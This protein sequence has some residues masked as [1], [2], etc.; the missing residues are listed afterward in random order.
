MSNHH[1]RDR[2]VATVGV[3]LLFASLCVGSATADLGG[4]QFL[5]APQI[6]VP[7]GE[8][9]E[10]GGAGAGVGV[11]WFRPIDPELS[12]VMSAATLAFSRQS[13]AGALFAA[14]GMLG[15]LDE[16]EVAYKFEVNAMT[17][18]AGIEYNSGEIFA[19]LRVGDLF[20]RI[21]ERTAL[22][23]GALR[24]GRDAGFR[25]R[26]RHGPL[27][28]V[29]AGIVRGDVPFAG[30]QLN[31]APGKRGPRGQTNLTWLSLFLSI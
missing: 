11:E 27:F 20:T 16:P 23:L 21:D 30:V 12:F 5:F 17:L 25:S 1:F 7:L 26:A 18:L 22:Y 6:V 19:S 28:A 29:S 3:Y 14:E 8:L 15:L 10:L 2:R 4:R 31:F 9:G 24:D 13:Q